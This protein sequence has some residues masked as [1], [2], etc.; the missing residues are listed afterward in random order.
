MLN[1]PTLDKLLEL[2]LLGMAEAF[3]RGQAQ[4]PEAAK[5]SFDERFGLLVDA[6]YS[7]RDNAAYTKRLKPLS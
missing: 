1:H 4:L 6:E 7:D 3:G 2:N 5:L